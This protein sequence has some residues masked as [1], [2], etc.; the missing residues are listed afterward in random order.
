MGIVKDLN[1]SKIPL[2]DLK[3]REVTDS[4]TGPNYA[5][6]FLRLKQESSQI[7]YS[8]LLKHSAAKPSEKMQTIKLESAARNHN[9]H[10]IEEESEDS[11]SSDSDND[12]RKSSSR[13]SQDSSESD[14][15]KKSNR[16]TSTKVQRMN[17]RVRKSSTGT[18]RSD[19]DALS[20]ILVNE[21]YGIYHLEGADLPGVVHERD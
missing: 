6:E 17:S 12:A 11:S 21:G 16:R 9:N 19:A 13:L 3:G 18:N 5:L 15:D 20:G 7:G 8:P 4:Q 14:A 1:D 10:H 2:Y